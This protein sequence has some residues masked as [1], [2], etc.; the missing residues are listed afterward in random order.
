MV[1][2]LQATRG[3]VGFVLSCAA[4]VLS[5]KGFPFAFFSLFGSALVLMGYQVAI[6]SICH[7]DAGGSTSAGGRFITICI[8]FAIA[9]V[10]SAVIDWGG[11]I[12]INFGD[13]TFSLRW[14]GIGMG[15]L[16]GLW[17]IDLHSGPPSL[18]TSIVKR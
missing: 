13:L 7:T 1:A 14:L 6:A 5:F 15:I 3:L 10:G 11:L 4:L 12:S 8:A 2:L 17:N 16:G 9:S 18:S